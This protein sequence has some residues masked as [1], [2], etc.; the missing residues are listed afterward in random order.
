MSI[1][2]VDKQKE[3]EVEEKKNKQMRNYK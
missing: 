2:V 3:M 1:V